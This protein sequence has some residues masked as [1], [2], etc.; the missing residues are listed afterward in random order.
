MT[1]PPLLLL[2]DRH[3]ARVAALEKHVAREA[4]APLRGQL[5]E[6]NRQALRSFVAAAGGIG[7]G[8]GG[9]ALAAYLADLGGRIQGLTAAPNAVLLDTAG[10][11]AALGQRQANQAVQAQG[12]APAPLSPP[13]LDAGV[14]AAVGAVAGTVAARLLRGRQEVIALGQ[15]PGGPGGQRQVSWGQVA[16][17]LTVA[18]SAATS[19][20]T[21]ATWVVHRQRAASVAQQTAEAGGRLLWI[22]EHGGCAY[23][24]AMAGRVASAETGFQASSRF[25]LRPLDPWP[26]GSMVLPP[27]HPHCRCIA[28]PYLGGDGPQ[29]LPGRLR[30]QAAQYLGSPTSGTDV[31][32]AVRNR[33]RRISAR[34]AMAQHHQRLGSQEQRR[35]VAA[36][37]MSTASQQVP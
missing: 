9:A 7:A 21:T 36:G 16:S 8:L 10:Q 31:P 37:L 15:G 6:L 19:I 24:Q 20:H 25:G 32:A 17:A 35:H 1:T 33:A 27:N 14:I 2:A 13:L 12:G 22:V 4:T 29:D 30:R 26:P 18:H 28:V 3:A 34:Y 23:C 5:V 11:A